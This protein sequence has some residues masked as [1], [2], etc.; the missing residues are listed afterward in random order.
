MELQIDSDDCRLAVRCCAGSG[1]PVLLLHGMGSSLLAWESLLP[2]LSGN[3]GVFALDLRGHGRSTA[4]LW[5]WESAIADLDA[6]CAHLNIR[7]LKLVGHSLGGI[8]AVLYASR[9][10]RVT[11]VVNLDGH[12]S[13]DPAL[14]RGRDPNRTQE[15]LAAVRRFTERQAGR[16]LSSEDVAAFADAAESRAWASGESPGIAREA[17]FRCLDVLPNGAYRLRPGPVRGRACSTRWTRSTSCSST[18]SSPARVSSSV[19]R[20]LRRRRRASVAR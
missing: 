18:R 13:S 1:E 11:G 5:T 14:S 7:R 15:K 19:R 2:T 6:V 3:H 9:R 17:I 20:K 16:Q 8:L 4:A 10:P 12:T